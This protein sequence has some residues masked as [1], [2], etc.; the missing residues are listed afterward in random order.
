[1]AC[2]TFPNSEMPPSVMVLE[3][4]SCSLSNGWAY[5]HDIAVV[6]Q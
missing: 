1:V 5:V 6:R 2:A 4:S 3:V